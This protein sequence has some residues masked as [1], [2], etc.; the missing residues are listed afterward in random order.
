MI[1]LCL[2]LLRF[3]CVPAYPGEAQPAQLPVTFKVALWAHCLCSLA[4][5]PVQRALNQ[6]LRLSG[7][8]C[9]PVETVMGY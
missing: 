3:K 2:E 9:S 8:Q 7:P 5:S 6:S 1:S 4:G